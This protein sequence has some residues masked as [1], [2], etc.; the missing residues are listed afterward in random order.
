MKG[1]GRKTKEKGNKEKENKGKIKEKK[2]REGTGG[3]DKGWERTGK[4][5]KIK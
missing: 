4:G 1:K 3:A 5:N 2:N